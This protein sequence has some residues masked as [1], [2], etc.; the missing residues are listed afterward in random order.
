MLTR[1]HHVGSVFRAGPNLLVTNDVA[2]LRKTGMA[3]SKYS[4]GEWYEA[5]K[6]DERTHNTISEPDE[7]KHSE[8]RYKL[9]HGVR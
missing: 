2:F 1:S 3:R 7:K 9:S 4:R 5:L 6:L 8:I